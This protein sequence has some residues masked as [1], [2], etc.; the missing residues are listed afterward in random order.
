[1]VVVVMMMLMR[2]KGGGGGDKLNGFDVAGAGADAGAL[3]A[4]HG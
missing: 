1:M 4:S 2:E 3:S